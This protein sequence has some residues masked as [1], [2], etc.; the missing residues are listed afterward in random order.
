MGETKIQKN[1][2][3]VLMCLGMVA[4]MTTYNAILQNGF[5]NIINHILEEVWIVFIIA[6]ILDFFLV[7]PFVKKNVFSRV[8]PE[9]KKLTIILSISLSMVTS[10]VL[11]MS[12]FGAIMSEGF[13]T[14]AIIIYP[15]VVLLNFIAALPIN[16][17]IVS[18]IARS[19]FSAIFNE[20]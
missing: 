14:N 20:K 3:T 2:F 18:P 4:C 16:L 1:I 9:T 10:M 13:T 6:F 19:I 12:I 17:I 5:T 8:K 7:G 11:L 15:K